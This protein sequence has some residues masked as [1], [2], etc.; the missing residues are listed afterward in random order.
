[1]Q[2]P[3]A[4]PSQVAPALTAHTL[5]ADMAAP[6]PRAVGPQGGRVGR[7]PG[8]R[9]LAA[10][11]PLEGEGHPCQEDEPKQEECLVQQMHPLGLVLQVIEL[12]NLRRAGHAPVSAQNAHRVSACSDE[13]P[14]PRQLIP[15]YNVG[16]HT[17]VRPADMHA[18]L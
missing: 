13:A 3:N 17:Q 8:G 2:S 9:T 10:D 18:V 4:W 7:S 16:V 5:P 12:E 15:C 14:T 1:M 6:Q 11:M